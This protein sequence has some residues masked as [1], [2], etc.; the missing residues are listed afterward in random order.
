MSFEDFKSRPG[1][2]ISN[3]YLLI[4]L[5]TLSGISKD[6]N[7]EPFDTGAVSMGATTLENAERVLNEK[8]SP[9]IGV[10]TESIDIPQAWTK[11]SEVL[12]TPD[13][14]GAEN[15]IVP[16]LE[17]ID[18][19]NVT[20]REKLELKKVTIG[21]GSETLE[22]P[23]VNLT[24][25]IQ[26]FLEKYI[27][28]EDKSGGILDISF[29]GKIIARKLL[30]QIEIK[31]KMLEIELSNFGKNIYKKEYAP[32]YEKTFDYISHEKSIYDINP[33]H[34]E[35]FIFLTCFLHYLHKNNKLE[36][37]MN[38]P[39]S[40]EKHKLEYRKK[41]GDPELEDLSFFID[42]FYKS[43]SK[44]DGDPNHTQI[45]EQIDGSEKEF[46]HLLVRNI[47]LGD[48]LEIARKYK[49]SF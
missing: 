48:V 13:S 5:L 20:A 18:N 36:S 15:E 33:G 25:N 43:W 21:E 6:K 19:T 12:N 38:V 7:T 49:N 32:K 10:Q 42:F 8:F 1:E 17:R 2:T 27:A 16:E 41:N 14:I 24:S 29:K 3:K 4:L 46:R 30:G 26:T 45:P 9:D 11:I 37:W 39:T 28:T 35:D 34:T 31:Q 47:S 44:M 40:L 22:E 23:V